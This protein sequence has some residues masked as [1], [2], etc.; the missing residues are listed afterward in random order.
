MKKAYVLYDAGT[1]EIIRIYRCMERAMTAA[2]NRLGIF[3]HTCLGCYYDSEY[4][5]IEYRDYETGKKYALLIE[6][7]D[8]DE[9][10]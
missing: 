9:E 6:E 3:R 8:E 10:E 7:A 1:C 5:V 4:A 2:I